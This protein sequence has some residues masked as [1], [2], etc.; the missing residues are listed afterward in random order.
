MYLCMYVSLYIHTQVCIYI[1]IQI[2]RYTHKIDRGYTALWL[3][4][5]FVIRASTFSR[6][7]QG[8][9]RALAVKMHMGDEAVSHSKFSCVI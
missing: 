9:Y 1:Y 7:V 4:S 8:E 5:S 3:P 6:L 2:D